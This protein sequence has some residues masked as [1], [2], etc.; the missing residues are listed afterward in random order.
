[1][2][3]GRD[4]SQPNVEFMPDMA[5]SVSAESFSRNAVFANGMTLQEPPQGTMAR[6]RQPL[7]YDETPEDAKRA[8]RDLVS[9]LD[10]EDPTTQELGATGFGIFCH[11]CHG[12]TGAGDGPVAAKGFPPP[13]SLF[14][15]QAN[16]LADGQMF[17]IITFGQKNMPAHAAQIPPTQRWQI[18]THVRELQARAV[19]KAAAD[20][21]AAQ[22]AANAEAEADV[23]ADAP[24]VPDENSE[25]PPDTGESGS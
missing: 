24:G 18:V 1:M 7:Y 15:E 21:A 19:T 13:P 5:Y 12:A 17:H 8:G 10:A 9:P 14:T 11:P 23:G 20:S 6:G 16:G 4:R 2:S 3:S 25:L 22:A